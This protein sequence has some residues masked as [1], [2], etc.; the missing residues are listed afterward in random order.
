MKD[1]KNLAEYLSENERKILPYLKIKDINE[2]CKK[3]NLD[4]VSAPIT[5]TF[6]YVPVAII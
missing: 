5:R 2:I 4:K 1:I 3:V 6:S